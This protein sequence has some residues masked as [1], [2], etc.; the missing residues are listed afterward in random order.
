MKAFFIVLLLVTIV[1][2][3]CVFLWMRNKPKIQVIPQKAVVDQM[4]NISISNLVAHEQV[5][6]ETSCKDKDDNIWLSRATFKADDKGMVNVATQAPISGSYKGIDPMGLFWSMTPVNP[7]NKHALSHFTLNVCEVSLSVFS[8]SKLRAQKVIHRLPVSSDVE[9][10]NIRENGVIGTLFYPKNMKNGPGLIVVP[11]SNG[12]IPENIAQP[13]A[14][15]GY[16]VLAL[17]YFAAEGLPKYL[18]NIPLEYFQ[19]AMQWFK[20]QPQVNKNKIA[21]CGHSR[22]AELVLLLAATFPEEMSAVIAYTTPSLV[23]GDFSPDEKAAWTFKGSPIP[24]MPNLSD[25]ETAK[26]AKDGLIP[27]HKGTLEDPLEEKDV[28]LYAMKKFSQNID[29][30]TIPVENLCCPLLIISGEDDKMWPAMQ[31]GDL[32]MERLAQKGST[33]QRE[34]LHY[35][36]AG[37]NLFIF[38]HF[39]SIDTPIPFGP[40]WG[41]L[42]GTAEGNAHAV[43]ESWQEV[44]N[45]LN[46]TLPKL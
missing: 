44:L 34:H 32:I 16:A 6:L 42:G 30:A 13:L 33:I 11:G 35:P 39:P 28:F 45:F 25:E 36:N 10:R 4:I 40:V 43:R 7:K 23:Y 3:F 14:S 17:G 46:R 38:P 8:Q 1:L 19:N 9:K 18:S 27:F 2:F 37:H 20:K 29:A 31:H 24:F 12:G 5:A 15:H 22:G 26:A 41:L 21:L